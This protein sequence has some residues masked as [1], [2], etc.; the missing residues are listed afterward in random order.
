MSKF[1]KKPITYVDY[2]SLKVTDLN[3][4][5]QF[6]KQILGF[7]VFSRKKRQAVLT[8]D[9][10]RPLLILEQPKDVQPKQRRTTGLYH[11]ALLLPERRD[12]ANFVQSIIDKG[13]PYGASDHRLT[14]AIY[15]NDPDGNGIEVYYDRTEEELGKK[16]ENTEMTTLPLDIRDVLKNQKGQWKTLPKKTI[17]GH[18]HLHVDSLETAKDFYVH[19]LGFNLM[20]EYPGALFVSDGGYHHHLGLNIWNGEGAPE[21]AE[22]SVGLNWYTIVLEDEEKLEECARKLKEKGYIV[23]KEKDYFE[24]GDPAGNKIRLIV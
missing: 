17:I 4:S 13:V 15:L 3:R 7:Q 11:F 8:A 16:R 24:T 12:L 6:Y 19:T 21:P 10:K 9:Q 1:H 20:T 5:L 14:E 22:N 2:L 18:I 23:T